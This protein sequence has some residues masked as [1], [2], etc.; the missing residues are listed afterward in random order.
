LAL[1]LSNRIITK[2][3]GDQAGGVQ[4]LIVKGFGVSV[5]IVV[6]IIGDSAK[7]TNLKRSL[8]KYI[9]DNVQVGE[10]YTISYD[11]VPFND[12][13]YD[14]WFQPRLT[15]IKRDFNRQVSST[16]YGNEAMAFLKVNIF[17]K[18][19]GVTLSDK[20]YLMRDVVAE[21]FKIG[22]E[23]DLRDY[24]GDDADVTKVKVR[25]IISEGPLPESINFLQ[26]EIVWQL[27]YTERTKNVGET[28]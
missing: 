9:Y 8:E 4:T 11:Q 23:I 17:V 12:K 21:H 1:Q 2:G 25:D 13:N 18:K 10:G 6:E 3:L 7:V 14:Y 16:E 22:Q 26:Y 19:S 20:H 5:A 28:S 24:V 15:G 27:N